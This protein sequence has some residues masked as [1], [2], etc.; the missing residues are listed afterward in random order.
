M[1]NSIHEGSS[2]SSWLSENEKFDPTFQEMVKYQEKQ[3]QSQPLP[4]DPLLE[5]HCLQFG[6]VP[7]QRQLD[8]IIYRKLK[9]KEKLT[10]T[11]KN[12]FLKLEK[13]LQ[14]DKMTHQELARVQELKRQRQNRELDE[15]EYKKQLITPGETDTGGHGN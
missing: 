4:P 3:A 2:S 5:K 11:E 6:I 9:S 13:F 1:E 12:T 7:N 8:R 14:S 10:K 15:L